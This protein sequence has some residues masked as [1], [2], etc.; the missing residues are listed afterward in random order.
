MAWKPAVLAATT[1]TA[2]LLAGTSVSGAAVVN[3]AIPAAQDSEPVILTGALIPDWSA[4]GD[5]SAKLPLTDLLACSGTIEPNGPDPNEWLVA[6]DN[7][8]HN[9]YQDPEVDPVT[10]G[11]G[12]PV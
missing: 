12:A 5:V 7:C 10:I 1:L 3:P 4:R 2:A 11:E 9:Q 8:E 6:D